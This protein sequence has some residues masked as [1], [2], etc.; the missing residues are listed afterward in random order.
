[1]VHCRALEGLRGRGAQWIRGA[2]FL[3]SSW[4]QDL[5]AALRSA[6]MV[7]GRALDGPHSAR[8]ITYQQWA[9]AAAEQQAQAAPPRGWIDLR[10]QACSILGTLQNPAVCAG[11]FVAPCPFSVC[12]CHANVE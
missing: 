6:V 9:Q 12:A 2:C 4:E 8:G 1:M 10:G 7:P 3:C 11:P 5:R